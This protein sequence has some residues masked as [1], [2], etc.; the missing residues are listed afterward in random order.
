MDNSL[1][2][3]EKECQ[4]YRIA[5]QRVWDEAQERETETI[6]YNP[7]T[8]LGTNRSKMGIADAAEGLTFNFAREEVP[9]LEEKTT[10][11]VII[12]QFRPPDQMRWW[13]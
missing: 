8:V 1:V 12:K 4:A 3:W 11:L 5:H 7:I 2:I 10:V 6:L 13:V 9:E